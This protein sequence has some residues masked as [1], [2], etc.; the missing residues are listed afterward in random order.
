MALSN[1]DS[2]AVDQN[3]ESTA[4]ELIHN[5]NRVQVYKNWLYV[6]REHGDNWDTYGEITEGRAGFGGIDIFAMRG[7]QNG[8][9]AVLSTLEDIDGKSKL[10]G[11]L[12]VGVSGFGERRHG[13]K[14]ADWV[15]VLPGSLEWFSKQ[16]N[17]LDIDDP[18]GFKELEEIW[19]Q[20]EREMMGQ[21]I[22]AL[23]KYREGMLETKK[24]REHDPAN[25]N[26]VIDDLPYEL[27]KVSFAKAE[28][29]N[30]GD[31]YLAE[32]IGIPL[33]PTKPGEAAPSLLSQMI[34]G[35]KKV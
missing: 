24:E 33:I 19:A 12:M 8:V 2:C 23:D 18:F 25:W 6:A 5:E 28:R 29:F 1:W 9:Y 32:K 16:L 10:V 11:K 7:P 15:G 31:A 35:M 20:G 34:K 22:A 27:R 17:A 13:Q 4:P 26:Y 14:Y 21:G 3:G 30:Q